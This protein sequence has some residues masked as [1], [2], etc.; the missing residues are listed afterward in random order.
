MKLIIT[1][2]FMS[3]TYLNASNIDCT[4]TETNI[5]K[6]ICQDKNLLNNY[7]KMVLLIEEVHKK[8][9]PSNLPTM[10]IDNYIWKNY[11]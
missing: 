10:H 8:V 4:N 6:S 1:I 5:A 7:N 2:I 3:V 9:D 11:L